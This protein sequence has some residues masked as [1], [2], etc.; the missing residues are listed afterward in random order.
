M[1]KTE[2]TLK[3]KNFIIKIPSS[4]IQQRVT[5]LAAEINSD[6][7]GKNPVIVGVLTGAAL[8]AVDLFKQLDIDCELT[9]IR[10]S[11]YEGGL[12]STG[13]VSAVV[14]LKE[15]I[16]NRHVLMIEDIVDTGH[17]AMHLFSELK[18]SN[19]A[20]LKIATALFKPAALQHQ[21][22]PDYT[23]FIVEPDFLVGYGLDYDGLGRN[24]NDIYVLKS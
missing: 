15:N 19:P 3:D 8:F 6:Y 2:V 17:T 1:S 7:Q 18:K 22:T 23:G 5:E 12:A 14:G 4:V 11:S 24:L 10:V 16:E 20:S 21:F 13:K 9:F